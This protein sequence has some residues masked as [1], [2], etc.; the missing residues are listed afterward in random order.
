MNLIEEL[1]SDLT[2]EYQITKKF[3]AKYPADKNTWKPHDKNMNTQDLTHHIIELFGWPISVFTADYIDFAQWDR[4][5]NKPS[6]GKEFESMLDA[7]YN[8]SMEVLNQAKVEDLDKTW[9]M[10]HGE[11]ILSEMNKFK[12]FNLNTRHIG[13]HRAQLGIYYRLNDIPVPGTIGP[14]ADEQ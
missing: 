1:K 5:P 13:H 3:L 10:R 12:A 2:N 4:N 6:N 11:T 8:K 7:I 14:S 9:Q